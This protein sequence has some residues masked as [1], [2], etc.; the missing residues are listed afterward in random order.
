MSKRAVNLLRK[1]MGPAMDLVVRK[2][3]TSGTL[4]ARGYATAAPGMLQKF[5]APAVPGSGN[6]T[7]TI[8]NLLTG[9]L[10][11]DPEGNATWTLPTAT[12]MVA[13]VNGVKV[14]DCFDFIVINDATT[15][16]DEKVTVAM[17]TDGTAVGLMIV[18]SNLVAGIRGH[19]SGAFRIRFTGVAA[20]SQ[21]YTCYRI[22]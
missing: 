12:L 2:A 7:I 9:I 18:D 16:V 10:H 19:G 1:Q 5:P 6:Q 21:A 17:G 20:G 11:D 22:G 3:T 13:G 14:G 4:F 8:A 15:T